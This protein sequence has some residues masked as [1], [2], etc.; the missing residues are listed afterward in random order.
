MP[1][2]A[3]SGPF[4]ER[5]MTVDRTV[6]V[7]SES[8]QPKFISQHT[9]GVSRYLEQVSGSDF[10]QRVAAC[11]LDLMSPMAGLTILEVGC[12]NGVLLPRLAQGVGAS[13]QVVGIDHAETFV[14]EA[15]TRVEAAGLAATV[16]VQQADAYHLPFSAATFDAAHCERVLMHLDDPSAALAEMKRVVR[17][18]GWIVAVEPDW[19]GVRVDHA[20]RAGMDLLYARAQVV[21]QTDMGITLY[22][23]MGE[24]GLVE[25]RA[26]PVL[27]LNTDFELLKGYGLTLPPAADALVAE[28]ALTRARADALLSGLEAANA[29]GHFY[30]AGLMHVVAGRVPA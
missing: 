21:R 3:D 11:A 5:T 12:G 8:W 18:G 29:A 26:V 9:A 22:R 17:A 2:A 25:R 14:A 13:G 10:G 7:T 19:D 6:P 16:T 20:D 1:H 27:F 30:C 24:L 4:K 23:R 15:R 28:G